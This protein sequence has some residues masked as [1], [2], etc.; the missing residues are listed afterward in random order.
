[1]ISQIFFH[2]PRIHN[3]IFRSYRT[4]TQRMKSYG[5]ERKTITIE[6]HKA[7]LREYFGSDDQHTNQRAMLLTYVPILGEG[8]LTP[9]QLS[10]AFEHYL[11]NLER[12]P[13]F[14][15]TETPQETVDWII[16]K[17]FYEV[18][19]N[20]KVHSSGTEL[21]T[22][23]VNALK[24]ASVKSMAKRGQAIVEELKQLS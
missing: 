6:Q 4:N 13:P 23:L 1:M 12:I 8:L 10:S 5:Q 9:T 24:T 14:Q 11:T 21:Q 16:K 20:G 2:Q 18:R 3:S 7:S 22:L 19:D 17:E 15:R